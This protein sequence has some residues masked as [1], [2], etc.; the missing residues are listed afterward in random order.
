L[1]GDGEV[2]YFL[3]RVRRSER[4]RE[5]NRRSGRVVGVA[6]VL[7]V[8]IAVIVLWPAPDPLRSA[9]TVYLDTGVADSV[10]GA[11]EV[12]EGLNFVLHDRSLTLVS[13]RGAA[14]VELRVQDVSV[15]LGD[16]TVTLGQGGI[17]GRVK[18][19]CRVTDLR[20]DRTHTMDLTVTVQ[21]GAVTAR[22]VGRKFWE[23]WK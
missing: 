10:R 22:L 11:A 1:T 9:R 4:R 8:A 16:V 17:R 19:V 15:N 21:D 23:F 18:A 5:M 20:S 13:D 6:S 3:A 12:E 14:D 2:C 7:A